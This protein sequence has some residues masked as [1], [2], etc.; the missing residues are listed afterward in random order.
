MRLE[1]PQPAPSSTALCWMH[2]DQDIVQAYNARRMRS[3]VA[4]RAAR[5]DSGLSGK[6]P[7]FPVKYRLF[8]QPIIPH[9]DRGADSGIT[10]EGN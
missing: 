5:P 6:S 9:A 1:L 7:R 8:A 10:E 4:D 3:P 2:Q